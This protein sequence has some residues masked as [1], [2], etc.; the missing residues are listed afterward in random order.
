LPSRSITWPAWP[1]PVTIIT[2]RTPPAAAAGGVVDHRPSAYGQQ[3]LVDDARQLT[4]PVASPP[5]AISP[6]DLH[7][8]ADATAG[9]AGRPLQ[10]PERELDGGPDPEP[11]RRAC[12]SRACRRAR[13]DDERR[14]LEARPGGADPIP[15][16]RE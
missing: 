2:S 12:R 4:E 14:E 11:R 8:A 3:V 1:W 6:L 10:E 13:T 15:S 5:A 7:S 9:P 16:R